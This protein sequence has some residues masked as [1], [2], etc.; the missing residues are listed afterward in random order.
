MCA[1]NVSVP[2]PAWERGRPHKDSVRTDSLLSQAVS[3]GTVLSTEGEIQAL[4]AILGPTGSCPRPSLPAISGLK[5]VRLC[6]SFIFI[7]LN[8]RAAGRCPIEHLRVGGGAG[9]GPKYLKLGGRVVYCLEDIEAFEA[10]SL[11]D[12]ATRSPKRGFQRSRA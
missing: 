2:R 11:R 12:P 5:R 1:R 3:Q 8:W 7:R 9:Q 4:R 6:R 10:A